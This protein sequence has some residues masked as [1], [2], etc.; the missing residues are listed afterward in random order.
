M[1][2]GHDIFKGVVQQI[3]PDEHPEQQIRIGV[4]IVDNKAKKKKKK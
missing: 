2:A 1:K 4:F 3:S